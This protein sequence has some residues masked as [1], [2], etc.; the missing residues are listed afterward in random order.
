MTGLV[1]KLKT[2]KVSELANFIESNRDRLLLHSDRNFV[3]VRGGCDPDAMHTIVRVSSRI[4]EQMRKLKVRTL[5]AH[6][7]S[8]DANEQ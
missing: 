8:L 2:I 3:V 6:L 5:V 4:T 7:A 1:D